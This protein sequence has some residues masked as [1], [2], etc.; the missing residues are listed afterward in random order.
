MPGDTYVYP[1]NAD[2][3]KF[4]TRDGLATDDDL[5]VIRGTPF[6]AEFEQIQAVLALKLNI[7]NPAFTGIMSGGTIFGGTYGT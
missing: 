6:D 7:N 3:I 5:K 1:E 4:G 2:G